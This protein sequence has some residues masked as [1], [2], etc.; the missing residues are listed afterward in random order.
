MEISGHSGDK[1]SGR[2]FLYGLFLFLP[3]FFFGKCQN[4]QFPVIALRHLSAT[5]SPGLRLGRPDSFRP[6]GRVE[7]SW[8]TRLFTPSSTTMDSLILPHYIYMLSRA[9]FNQSVFL[10]GNPLVIIE[11]GIGLYYLTFFNIQII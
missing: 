5:P 1:R 7:G 4:F 10:K 2:G 11:H 8:L 3:F 6:T 9:N